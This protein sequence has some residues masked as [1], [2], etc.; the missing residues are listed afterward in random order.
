MN[1]PQ[2]HEKLFN[3][4]L[5][6]AVEENLLKSLGGLPA[7]EI[8]NEENPLSDGLCQKLKMLSQKHNRKS[9]FRRRLRM[10]KRVAVFAVVGFLVSFGSLLSVQ[11]SRNVIFNAVK[12]WKADHVDIY[13]QQEGGNSIEQAEG[14]GKT[15]LT[16]PYLPAGFSKKEEIQIGPVHRTIYQNQ[17]NESIVFDQV[18]LSKEGK[19]MVDT[20]HT[21]YQEILIKGRKASLFA[22]KT[23]NDKSLILWQDGKTSL[24]ISAKI[25]KDEL[26][27]MAEKAE[28]AKK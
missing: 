17:K 24:K 15:L 13:F 4:M 22:A 11:A 6:A 5:K 2:L 18:P 19:M 3:D 10:I 20:E 9:L 27:R 8:L 21:D 7:A 26:I 16:L 28:I 1:N 25:D 14:S 23:A 12:E